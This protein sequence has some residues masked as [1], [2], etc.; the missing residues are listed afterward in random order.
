MTTR[1]FYQVE[2]DEDCAISLPTCLKESSHMPWLLSS[3]RAY[4]DCVH[5]PIT[6]RTCS[7]MDRWFVIVMP[8]IL[9]EVTRRMPAVGGGRL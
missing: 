1:S 9:M 8:S 4:R 5:L 6:S 7:P 3:L 2:H